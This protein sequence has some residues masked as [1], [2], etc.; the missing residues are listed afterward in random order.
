VFTRIIKIAL[1]IL[2][3][4]AAAG[5]AAY[6]SVHLMIRSEN[7]AVVP[8]LEGREAVYA[9]EVLT[10]LKLN[11]KVRRFEFSATVP[12]HH[13]ISQAPEAG[14]EIKEGRDVRLV[15]SRGTPTVVYPNVE[16][17]S[18]SL[19][20]ILMNEND[21]ERGL[22]TYTSSA[23]PKETVLAQFPPAGET[24]MRGDAVDLLVSAGPTPVSVRMVDLLGTGLDHAVGV[25]ERLK[26]ELGVITQKNRPGIPNETVLDQAPPAG[27]PVAP[28]ETVNLSIN[29][30]SRRTITERS[31]GSALFRYRLPL[32][33]LRQQVRVRIS[34]ANLAF[35]LVD[36]FAKPGEEIWLL[37]LRDEPTT[38]FLHLDGELKVTQH[39][40]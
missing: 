36:R 12:K 13:V 40:E 27:Y 32:G 29:R 5:A 34:R 9:L 15:I 11:T 7:V 31:S 19:A 38:L 18:L 37:I 35:N 3:F 39:F 4:M 30:H 8:N 20:T 24:G 23:L 21:L 6:F 16:E 1:C 26:L 14:R 2:V 17:T 22:L 10:D 25:I 33:F 28:G